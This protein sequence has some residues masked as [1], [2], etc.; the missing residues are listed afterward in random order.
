MNESFLLVSDALPGI[1][2]RSAAPSDCDDLR[3]WKNENRQ[4]FF[5]R[6][7]I[8][9]D[10]QRQWFA[11]YRQR[12]DDWMFMVLDQDRSIGCMGFRARDG[13]ADVYNV[14][15]GRAEHGGRGVMSGAF[16]M[17]CSFARERLGVPVVARVL[18]TNP[19]LGWYRKR[20]FD[21]VGDQDEHVMIALG[22]RFEPVAVSRKEWTS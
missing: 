6:D 16:R 22:E 14:I 11:G 2:L 1:S 12:P 19:A 4:Y 10:G 17:M 21:V 18:K 13:Q 3:A 9:A 15:L 20:G 5:F 7:L 8:S